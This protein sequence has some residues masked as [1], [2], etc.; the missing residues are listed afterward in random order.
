MQP[1]RAAQEPSDDPPGGAASTPAR[2][3]PAKR[4]A[5][6]ALGRSLSDFLVEFSIVLHNRSMYPDDHPQL[7]NAADRFMHRLET[8][9]E[10]RESIALGV[11]SHQLIVDGVA[12]DPANALLR[13]LARRLNR[14]QLTSL[15]FDRG[16]TLGEIDDLLG[17]L[18]QDATRPPGALGQRLDRI[19]H[20]EHLR[21]TAV[22][23]GR[24]V[25]R[26]ESLVAPDEPPRPADELWLG[27]A[28]LADGEDET[29]DG[30]GENSSGVARAIEAHAG[31]VAYDRV[32]LDYLT[33][34]AEEMSGRLSP[35]EDRLRTRVSALIKNLDPQRLRQ[36][37]EVG[38]NT[39]ATRQF[40]LNAAQTLAVDAVVEVLE[41]AADVSQQTISHHL[42]RLLRKLARQ[43]TQGSE[44]VRTE[45]DGALRK[46]VA[47]L[48]AGWNLEDPNPTG[49]TSLLDSMATDSWNL[50]VDTS[51][52]DA[53]PESVLQ[54][55]LE[56]G[57]PGPRVRA[58]LNLLI[59]RGRL[60]TVVSLLNQAPVP[61]T[62][63]ALWEVVATPERLATELA[64]ARHDRGLIE[65]LANKAGPAAVGPLFAQLANADRPTRAWLLQV[66]RGL[67]PPAAA[68]AV[69]HASD[70]RWYIRRNSLVLLHRMG[71]WPTGFSP[72]TLAGDPEPQVRRAAIRLAL[73]SAKL[74]P[75]ALRAALDDPD[76]R[77]LTLGLVAAAGGCPPDLFSR[78][79]ATVLDPSLDP[80]LRA[81]AVRALG[82]TGTPA[83]RRRL[84]DIVLP[85]RRWLPRRLAPPSPPVLAALAVIA[86]HWRDDP[87]SQHALEKASRHADPAVRAAAGHAP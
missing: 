70:P 4:R 58:A 63:E 21:L 44:Q 1:A 18:C 5:R 33:R 87:E 32:V 62:A 39:Q 78:L 85:E 36:L 30:A 67:G 51:T 35:A 24:L 31:E 73:G 60:A 22:D 84:I 86:T 50:A 83:A 15:R 72:L 55:G 45:A 42:L 17:A 13:D 59:A 64:S 80:E 74:R 49:Y 6:T 68:A 56:V 9:L 53:D 82:A 41:A 61:E 19:T 54:L 25:Y 46:H 2:R 69:A 75:Q 71:E 52:L 7:R 29:G 77:V 23:Y 8:V 27:L 57:V 79:E 47:R 40:A 37:L 10:N 66:L 28:R 20:W 16:V 11:A 14:H 76:H 3:K 34:I 12:T 43:A 81:L 48:L 26:D 65:Q 38:A